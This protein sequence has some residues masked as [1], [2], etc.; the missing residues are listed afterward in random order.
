MLA[1]E[2]VIKRSGVKYVVCPAFELL[3]IGGREALERFFAQRTDTA[4]ELA[5][6]QFFLAL[7]HTLLHANAV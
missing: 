1:L 4:R 6:K 3:Q 2:D 5:F 7:L